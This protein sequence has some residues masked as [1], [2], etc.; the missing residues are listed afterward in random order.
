MALETGEIPEE[1]SAAEREEIAGLVAASAGLHAVGTSLEQ[2]AHRAIPV[3]R[4]RFE[5]FVAAQSN[6]RGAAV[7]A[8]SA[9][10]IGWLR[11]RRSIAGLGIAAVVG[12]VAVVAVF[13]YQ[14]LSSTTESVNALSRDDYVQVQGVIA[15]SSG[16]APE[17]TL[18]VHSELGDVTVKVSGNTHTV[19]EQASPLTDALKP[20]ELVLVAGTV[21]GAGPERTIEA[22]TI[23]IGA[24]GTN[25]PP[26]TAK[27]RDLRTL[28]A[29]LH[30]RVRLLALSKDGASGRVVIE[31]A[32]GARYLVHINSST[33][34][35]LLDRGST[36]IGAGVSVLPGSDANDGVFALQVDDVPAES[37]AR[38]RLSFSGVRGVAAARDGNVIEVIDAAGQTVRATIGPGT[39]VVLG[40]S[41]LTRA[42]IGKPAALVGHTVAVSGGLDVGT[43]T[44]RS[45]LI[46]VGPP[47]RP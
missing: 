36:A 40:R 13:A 24:R 17:Q 31:S 3:A 27:L 2:E 12:L 28:S 33:I 6:A 1:A 26:R 23:A 43:G 30:G 22:S 4:A 11:G 46:I 21:V 34:E 45:D 10:G 47:R 7:T 5:R 44:I 14:S 35:M 19:G 37:G 42:D 16:H 41:G 29:A 8:P 39:V 38:P 15:S 20:G 32:N 18:V 25:P 9:R